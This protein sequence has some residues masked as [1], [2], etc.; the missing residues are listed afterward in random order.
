MKS[1]ILGLFLLASTNGYGAKNDGWCDAPKG[2]E[3]LACASPYWVT[4]GQ[5]YINRDKFRHVYDIVN[6]S[7]I[8]CWW[9]E[10]RAKVVRKE[11]Y[12]N[13]RVAQRRWGLYEIEHNG[14]K[15]YVSS[16]ACK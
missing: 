6:S 3:I 11:K 2:G 10:D 13:F 7:I 8:D 5:F 12:R 9:I 4:T 1:I 16:E 14:Y 15:G